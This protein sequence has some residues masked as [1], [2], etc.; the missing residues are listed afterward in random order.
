MVALPWWVVRLRLLCWLALPPP[1]VALIWWP[2]R[3]HPHVY[4]K[5]RKRDSR[6]G[7]HNPSLKDTTQEEQPS[8]HSHSI[9]HMGDVAFILGDYVSRSKPE[10]LLCA[11]HSIS[12]LHIHYFISSSSQYLE[13]APTIPS[14]VAEE[15][16][17]ESERLGKLP[18]VT[19]LVSSRAYQLCES[20]SFWLQSTIISG[21]YG[22]HLSAQWWERKNRWL[23]V[24]GICTPTGLALYWACACQQWHSD[25]SLPSLWSP[26]W[27]LLLPRGPPIPWPFSHLNILIFNFHQYP[28]SAP[29]T[30][31]WYI[32]FGAVTCLKVVL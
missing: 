22:N 32:P 11:R 18:K 3:S 14:S 26:F 25:I 5:I 6:W 19:Q 7:R 1:G 24:L 8:L 2:K 28:L 4:V 16:N 31:L 17:R 29:I 27:E 9:G 23:V 20:K 12:N 10:S 21:N 30:C 13:I 15:G